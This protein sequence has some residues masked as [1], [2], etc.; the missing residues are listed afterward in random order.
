MMDGRRGRSWGAGVDGEGDWVG[1]GVRE[2]RCE[3]CS[4]G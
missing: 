4:L 3:G 2:R 1:A